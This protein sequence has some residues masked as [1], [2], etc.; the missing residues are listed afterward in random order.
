MF[1]ML[2]N[3][4]LSLIDSLALIRILY[5]LGNFC[6]KGREGKGIKGIGFINNYKGKDK[7]VVCNIS[8]PFPHLTSVGPVGD[9]H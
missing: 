1:P 6:Q 3:H 9:S 8:P 2:C 7:F 4:A 5:L